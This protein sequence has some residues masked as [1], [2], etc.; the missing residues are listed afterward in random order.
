MKYINLVLVIL[1]MSVV[2][3][4]AAEPAT[5]DIVKALESPFAIETRAE[6]RI[7]DFQA[8]FSQVSHIASINREQRGHGDVRFKFID[9]AAQQGAKVLFRW[10]Y[11]EPDIQEIISDGRMMWVYL[12]ENR[13]VI[14]SDLS[15]V[16][17]QGPNPVTFLSNLGNLSRDF[18][19][20]RADPATDDSGNFRLRLVPLQA[21]P[22]FSS[23]DAVV[24]KD[25]VTNW[26]QGSGKLVF[27][28]LKTVVTDLQGNSTAIEFDHIKINPGLA[29]E[30]FVFDKPADVEVVR[31][32]E[33]LNFQ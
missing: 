14:E 2:T 21:S 10:S 17:E 4:L 27:P 33:Q 11:L 3:A 23:M 25:A 32:G 24:S 13:Q 7:H 16:Q 28:L 30:L 8:D 22:Q 6:G 31:A 1:L 9:G 20:A 15:Q 26:Q 29:T 19:I 18:S 12:P 5:A